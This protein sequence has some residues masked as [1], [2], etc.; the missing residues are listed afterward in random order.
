METNQHQNYIIW[1]FHKYITTSVALNDILIQDLYE[2]YVRDIKDT[3]LL[4]SKVTTL[5]LIVNMWG[6][7]GI[8][9]EGIFE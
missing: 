7:Y 1:I 6:Q 3:L 5:E 8:I 4:F 2:I 9:M